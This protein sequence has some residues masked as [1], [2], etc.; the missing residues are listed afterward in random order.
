MILGYAQLKDK[1]SKKTKEDQGIHQVP[2]F[3][4]C[5]TLGKYTL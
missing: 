3:T 4:R 1:E 2:P 5:V